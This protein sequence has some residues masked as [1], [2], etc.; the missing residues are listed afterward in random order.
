MLE[1]GYMLLKLTFP[2]FWHPA[3][4]DFSWTTQLGVATS[5]SSNQW[6]ARTSDLQFF[7]AWPLQVPI[8]NS[9]LYPPLSR[10]MER[11]QWP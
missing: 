5:L 4:L 8:C 2:L 6:N 10:W 1:T 11:V 3:R 7:Q 9:A